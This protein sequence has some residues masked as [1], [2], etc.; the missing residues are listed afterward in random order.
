[1]TIY[2]KEEPIAKDQLEPEMRKSKTTTEET[3][4]SQETNEANA[5]SSNVSDLTEEQTNIN[6]IGEATGACILTTYDKELTAIKENNNDTLDEPVTEY[7]KKK[8]KKRK[9]KKTNKEKESDLQGEFE[10]TTMTPVEGELT[11]ELMDNNHAIEITEASAVTSYEIELTEEQTDKNDTRE[12]TDC[13]A[14]VAQATQLTK[15]QE[16]KTKMT[17]AD[18]LKSEKA[19][20]KI[21]KHKRRSMERSEQSDVETISFKFDEEEE[22][23]HDSDLELTNENGI[24]NEDDTETWFEKSCNRYD[25]QCEVSKISEDH[26]LETNVLTG[27]ELTDAYMEKF[28]TKVKSLEREDFYTVKLTNDLLELCKTNPSLYVHCQLEI[29]SSH[30]AVAIPLNPVQ[31]L[32]RIDILGRSKCGQA[33]TEDEVAVEIL[34]KKMCKNTSVLKKELKDADAYGKVV[35]I[36]KRVRHRNIAHPVFIA[37]Q[38]PH[39]GHLMLP[40]CKTIPKISVLTENIKLYYPKQKMNKVEVYEYIQSKGVLRYKKILHIRPEERDQYRFLICYLY[41]G[42]KYVYPRGAVIGVLRTKAS[43]IGTGLKVIGIQNQVPTFYNESTVRGVQHIIAEPS[44]SSNGS[45]L[46]LTKILSFTIDPPNARDLDDALSVEVIARDTYQVGVHIADVTSKIPLESDIDKEARIRC[47]TYYSI[48]GARALHML[49]EPLSQDIL[50]LLPHQK[51]AAISVFFTVKENGSIEGTP[52]IRRTYIQSKKRLTYKEAQTMIDTAVSSHDRLHENIKCL[53]KLAKNRRRDRLKGSLHAFPVEFDYSVDTKDI[54][55]NI[56]AHN[57]V[58][59]FMIMANHAVGQYLMEECNGI[60]PLRCQN[61]PENDSLCSWLNKNTH[62]ADIIIALQDKELNTN[63]TSRTLNVANVPKSRWTRLLPVQTW[64]WKAIVNAA[65]ENNVQRVEQLIGCD[66]LHPQQSFALQEWMSF[67]ETARYT[68]TGSNGLSETDSNHFS[69]DLHNY[70]HFTSP[71][72]R[73]VDMVIHRLLHAAIDRH[74]QLPYTRQ[75]IDEICSDMNQACERAKLYQKQCN[76]FLQSTKLKSHPQ[77]LI[78]FVEDM[79]D[80]GVTLHFPGLKHVQMQR[81]MLKFNILGVSSQ[82]QIKEDLDLVSPNT[83][84]ERVVTS[85]IWKKRIY[86]HKGIKKEPQNTTNKDADDIQNVDPHQRTT[87]LKYTVWID[88]LTAILEKKHSKLI[89][90]I[91][92]TE[93][94]AKF[95]ASHNYVKSSLG[96]A[97]DVSCENVSS[98]FV[99]PICKFKLPFHLNQTVS[100][101]MTAE[102]DKGTLVPYIQVFDMTQNVSFCLQH[103]D[104]P[105]K[106]LA[107]YSSVP[108]VSEYKSLKH[109]ISTWLPIIQMEAATNAV[110]NEESASVIGV[111]IQFLGRNGHFYLNIHFCRLREIE[112]GNTALEIFKDNTEEKPDVKNTEELK[113]IICS[114][115]LCIRCPVRRN[116]PKDHKRSAQG[117][118]V[119]EK[120]MWICHGVFTHMRKTKVKENGH[121]FE[122]HFK[123]NDDSAPAPIKAVE[124]LDKCS[125]EILSK[126][127]VDRRTE[128]M[129]KLL[130]DATCLAQSIAL[131][132]PIPK[133]DNFHYEIAD[134]IP[135]DIEISSLPKNNQQQHKAIENALTSRF[136][137]IQGPPGTGKTFTGIKLIYL[138]S[139]FNQ[140]YFEK[141]HERRQ[142]VF[143]G[144][145]NKSVDLVARQVLQRLSHLAPRIIR[146]YGQAY[147]FLDFPI[148]G[149]ITCSRRSIRDS[150][151]DEDLKEKGA[152]LHHVIRECG[153]PYAESLKSFDKKFENKSYTASIEEIDK[154]Q[155]ILSKATQ[156]ELMNYDVILCTASM[157]GNPKLLKATKGKVYQ[158]IIDE[159]GMCTEPE[160]MVPPIATRAEQVVLIGDHKQLQPII[161]CR[162]AGEMGL[163]TSLFER[164]ANLKKKS[165]RLNMKYTMLTWQYRMNPKICEFPSEKFYGGKLKTANSSYWK[166]DKPL[167]IWNNPSSNEHI[168]L[169]FCHIEGTEET[170]TVSTEEGNE[171]SRKNKKE[172]EHVARVFKHL[173]DIEKVKVS[174]I[175]IMTQYNAQRHAIQEILREKEKLINIK[176][177]TV[178]KSQGSEWDYVIFSTV[179]SLPRYLIENNPTIGWCIQNLGFITDQHQVNVALTR[180]RRGLIIVGNKH[181][182]RC[183]EVWRDLITKYEAKDLVYSHHEFPPESHRR[184]DRQQRPPRFRRN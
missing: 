124:T 168:P 28:T 15:E 108:S 91:T 63:L 48:S 85:V 177:N 175:Q 18:C 139:L 101:Q 3:L 148:P 137:L 31:E 173:I 126:S 81:R 135:R 118:I 159:C 99:N 74:E 52:G 88:I 83:R 86:L 6:N 184:Q 42:V 152:V 169:A 61:K 106:F 69:L 111:P 29:Q 54:L 33:F 11:E 32:G 112:F 87:F 59:E 109:Y 4:G 72:R 82:P 122:V 14:G 113:E 60:V 37:T 89:K 64:V 67:Q 133:L 84:E 149:K 97:Q 165:E 110:R 180:A 93:K 70:V 50:S 16:G 120:K 94:D 131:A 73:Y 17:Y 156:E 127:K 130:P 21:S 117:R 80:E 27:V 170:L 176:V 46:D 36:I 40:V 92:D 171:Q 47:S 114:N 75:E 160:C 161:L 179:R 132:N 9:K 146:M 38:D 134:E 34:Q 128:N 30:N 41:W 26:L 155:E 163:E 166:V 116:T 53:N 12:E 35:G 174:N 62:L 102:Y 39:A 22:D 77:K 181:L 23:V 129:M 123:L 136:S 66:D 90:L 154:Y 43:D 151:P 95:G 71:I 182:L 140:K 105:V 143:S 13:S 5:A 103:V 45:R 141:T 100:V 145:S 65:E 119:D 10:A 56:D 96:A 55:Q 57:L 142:V 121:C 167:R 76:M 79:S 58:E 153:K 68:C 25:S 125:L 1:M 78:G 158:C 115:Y 8:R 24:Y 7:K 150:K 183:D 51:R 98:V 178:V 144:P 2:F 172:A 162:E 19:E 49:P 104:N 147:E 164:Y 107:K 157:A 138:F 20:R 44:E